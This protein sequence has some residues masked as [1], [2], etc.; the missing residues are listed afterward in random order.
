MAFGNVKQNFYMGQWVRIGRMP[1]GD[2]L[3]GM[4]CRV[5]GVSSRD[6]F[7]DY[8]I[9]L[10]TEKLSYNDMMAITMIETCLEPATD[11]QYWRTHSDRAGYDR[12]E[13]K[14]Q[15]VSRLLRG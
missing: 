4:L 9:V 14:S 2:K 3:E 11:V 10:L 5:I 13:I 1:E 12:S 6:S 7:C 15:T 8:Y